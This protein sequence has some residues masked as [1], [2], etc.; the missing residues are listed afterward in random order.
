M[1]RPVLLMVGDFSEEHIDVAALCAQ[2]GWR[3]KQVSSLDDPS[4]K[5]MTPCA[6]GLIDT[7]L[8]G[9]S[10][11]RLACRRFPGVHWIACTRFSSPTRWADLERLGAFH[12][13]YRPL[14][15]AEFLHALGFVDAVLA[16]QQRLEAE[17]NASNAA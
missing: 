15:P 8:D 10:H 6:A 12:L 3:L 9:G 17:F 16:Q 14:C 5:E 11:L 4:L 1:S 13:L 7:S 2:L